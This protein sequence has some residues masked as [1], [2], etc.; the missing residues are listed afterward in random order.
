MAR[1][2]VGTPVHRQVHP[3]GAEGRAGQGPCPWGSECPGAPLTTALPAPSCQDGQ[4]GHAPPRPFCMQQR[5]TGSG[6]VLASRRVTPHLDSR[7][8]QGSSAPSHPSVP[9][10][11]ASAGAVAIHKTPTP[12]SGTG[13]WG[14]LEDSLGQLG[15]ASW[16]RVG[17]RQ[18]RG[19]CTAESLTAAGSDRRHLSRTPDPACLGG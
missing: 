11:A 17:L 7:P 10:K 13:A 8:Q 2:A 16:P 19:D 5:F 9:G 12:S 18:S 6:G 3:A 14:M 4:G 15:F 1:L